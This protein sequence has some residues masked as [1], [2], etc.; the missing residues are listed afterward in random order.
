MK[1]DAHLE[2]IVS[3][4]GEVAAV[5]DE[6]TA[7]A[8]RQLATALRNSIRVRILA[9][10]SEAAVEISSQLPGGHVEVQLAGQDPTL[11]YVTRARES[12]GVSEDDGAAARISLRLSESLKGAAETAATA[13]GLSLNAWI[14]RAISGAVDGPRSGRGFGSRLKGFAKG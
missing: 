12:G 11:V 3:D 1:L 9:A 8:A 14:I 7:A 6:R 13:D 2:A 4:L 10:V 5:G